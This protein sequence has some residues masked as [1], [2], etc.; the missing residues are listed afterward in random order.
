MCGS[1]K[2]RVLIKFEMHSYVDR[3]YLPSLTTHL[4]F[5]KRAL[6]SMGYRLR[7][8][9]RSNYVSLLVFSFHFKSGL[10]V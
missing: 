4:C 3:E 8:L 1:E 2:A 6:C 7:S 5:C 9:L 10:P